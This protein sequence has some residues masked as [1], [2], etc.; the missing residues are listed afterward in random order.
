MLILVSGRCVIF[1][2]LSSVSRASQMQPL[3]GIA[4]GCGILD[5]V[6]RPVTRGIVQGTH[7]PRDESSKG[8]S[9]EGTH[10]TRDASSKGHIPS[11]EKNVQERYVRGR[12]VMVS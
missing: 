8:R 4:A 10:C 1:C 9:V 2:Q 12:I 11:K 3:L 6:Q 7:R 5:K